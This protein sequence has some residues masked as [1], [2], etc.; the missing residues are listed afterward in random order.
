MNRRSL[1]W[2]AAVLLAS[3]SAVA[4]PILSV[5]R[6]LIDFGDVTFG[7]PIGTQ[8]LNVTNVGDA[9]LALTGFGLVGSQRYALGGPCTNVFTLA[10]GASCRFDITLTLTNQVAG[11]INA[12]FDIDSNGGPTAQV[13]LH[14]VNTG[15]PVTPATVVVVE[16]YNAALDHYFITWVPPRSPS[17][18]RATR[19]RA[20]RAPASR[21]RRTR[22]RRPARRRYAATTF[23]RASATRTSSAAARPSATPPARRIRA[24]CSKIPAFMQM[25]LPAAG[26]CPADTTPDLSRVQQPGG[27]QSPLHDRPSRARPDGGEGLAGR[28]RRPDLV[29]MCA[30][31]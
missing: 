7:E 28:R 29:V 21:S 30:P 22:R 16:Y 8:A 5:S 18:M 15:A 17:S 3:G 31:A 27:R 11:A 13:Q 24:S 9:P 25:Y 2:L 26:V 19:S 12:R 23:R 4:A 14:A 10:P 1:G 20:G 6:T